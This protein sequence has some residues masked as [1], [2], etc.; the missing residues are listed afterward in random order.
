MAAAT[1]MI[2]PELREL[3]AARAELMLDPAGPAALARW[4]VFPASA[5]SSGRCG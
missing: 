3:L 1:V 2:S 4:D 5:Q